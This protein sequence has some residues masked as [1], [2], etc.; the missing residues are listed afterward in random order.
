MRKVHVLPLVGIIAAAL[1]VA[2]C[3]KSPTV[4]EP[5]A[6]EFAKA[7]PMDDDPNTWQLRLAELWQISETCEYDV[8]SG[9][10]NTVSG[11]TVTG[12]PPSW[13]PNYTCSIEVPGF[14][15]P[16]GGG[17]DIELSIHI[18]RN[19]AYGNYSAVYKLEPDGA[20]FMFPVTVTL[21]LPPWQG[22]AEN[23]RKFCFFFDGNEY[24]M[25]DYEEGS[26]DR[27]NGTLSV[28]FATNHFSRWAVED[29]DK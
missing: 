22:E 7:N 25:S 8:I 3:E 10:V 26:V 13:G 29:G 6:G 4:I 14:A 2:A 1:L 18:Q 28:Q 24:G 15:G 19:R 5:V 17:D 12:S 23:C 16:G 9:I 11:G 20:F 21:A 27:I